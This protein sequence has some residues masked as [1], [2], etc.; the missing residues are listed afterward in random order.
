M[1]GPA[2]IPFSGE[3]HPA[4]Q[5]FPLMGEEDLAALAS[6]I[7]ANGLR[8]PLVLDGEGRLLDGRNRL[9]ACKRAKVEPAFVSVNGADPVAVVVSLNVK[10]RNLTASQRAIGAA[11]A[12]DMVSPDSGGKQG[13]AGVLGS[14][15]GITHSY[16]Q[17]AR[18]LDAELA[19]EV[20]A[21]TRSLADA[22]EEHQIR[23]RAA[24]MRETSI[25][26]IRAEHPDL[27]DLVQA[28]Q[29]TLAEAL[30][31]GR[32]REAEILEERR[33]RTRDLVALCSS[34]PAHHAER[35]AEMYDPAQDPAGTVSAAALRSA[36]TFA[37]AVADALEQG[38]TK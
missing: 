34:A 25:E 35:F 23:K 20:K 11:E 26:K 6:D 4:A 22:Y 28:D 3:L 12:W 29:L 30:A 1:A 2:V 15:F 21:G 9:E 32:Q 16:V 33:S 7:K 36:A 27:A 24:T 14:R 38:A 31:A 37:S 13:R 10:R 19:A 18:A 17:Q 5:L 8:Q